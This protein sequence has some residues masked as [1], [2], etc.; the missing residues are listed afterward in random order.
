MFL[1]IPYRVVDLRSAHA[2]REAV[3]LMIGV[4]VQ[5]TAERGEG[6]GMS[7][8][9][10]AVVQR[11]GRP[12]KTGSRDVNP[13]GRRERVAV[14]QEPADFRLLGYDHEFVLVPVDGVVAIF[15]VGIF[16]RG[17]GV[18]G[19]E[20]FVRR[21]DHHGRVRRLLGVLLT[22]H[23]LRQHDGLVGRNVCVLL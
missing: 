7:D 22:L 1:A 9:V 11:D 18:I 8:G 2:G 10:G 3:R 19:A 6:V 12:N 21:D 23:E 13:V 20:L 5:V 4:A 16:R 14:Q 15:G 17:E